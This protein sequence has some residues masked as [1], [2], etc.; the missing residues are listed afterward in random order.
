M[1]EFLF[2]RDAVH[3]IDPS[4]KPGTTMFALGLWIRLGF[5]GMC[6]VLLSLVSLFDGEIHFGG[7][8]LLAIAGGLLTLASWQRLRKAL[9][10]EPLDARAAS[11][12]ALNF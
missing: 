6:I 10:E 5:A 11:S 12:V 2:A 3:A 4:A 7:A 1:N 9:R 8:P